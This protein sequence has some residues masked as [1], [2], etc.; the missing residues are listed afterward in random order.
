MP[1]QA[2]YRRGA[3]SHLPEDESQ[4]WDQFK[5]KKNDVAGETERNAKGTN[6]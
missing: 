1:W 3:C 5:E 6:G 4:V 2:A